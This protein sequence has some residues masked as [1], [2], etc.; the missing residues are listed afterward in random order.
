[1]TNNYGINIL[2]SLPLEARIVFFSLPLLQPMLTLPHFPSLPISL[3]FTSLTITA[4]RAESPGWA[5]CSRLPGSETPKTA[6]KALSLPHMC[7][8]RLC[9]PDLYPVSHPGKSWGWS[10]GNE[11]K[12][13]INSAEL[14]GLEQEWAS[15]QIKQCM[16]QGEI[17]R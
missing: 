7:L 16:N 3:N 14:K 10:C 4:E 11:K 8:G 1:M 2:K 5:M 6:P 17:M 15:S 13:E 12:A 9:Q